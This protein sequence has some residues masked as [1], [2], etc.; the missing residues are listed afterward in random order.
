LAYEFYSISLP[1]IA[2][3]ITKVS[4]ASSVKAV[5][6]EGYVATKRIIT[7]ITPPF[8]API[9]LAISGERCANP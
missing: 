9:L 7:S 4:A 1:N 6:Q 3:D 2:R 8:I 5:Y